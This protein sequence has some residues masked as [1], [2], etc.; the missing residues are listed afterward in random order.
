MLVI[1]VGDKEEEAKLETLKCTVIEKFLRSNRVV[2]K[3][4]E[5]VLKRKPTDLA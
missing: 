1:A 4:N 3:T 2:R 5:K